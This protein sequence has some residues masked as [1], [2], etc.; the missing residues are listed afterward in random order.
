MNE[1]TV[2]W[3]VG[4]LLTLTLTLMAAGEL[5][6]IAAGTADSG[7]IFIW[8][9]ALVFSGV[10]ALIATRQPGNAIGWIFLSVGVS[11]GLAS[12]SSGYADYW[13]GGDGGSKALG[14]AAATY[15]STAWVPF[16]VVPVTFLL[17]LFPDGH[18]LSRR[19]R[20]IARLAGLAIASL[21]LAGILTP[22]PLEDYPQISS[23]YAIDSPL[24][25]PLAGLAFLALLVAVVG[26]GASLV[27][28]FR[29]ATG[30]QRQQM[31]WLALA[32]ASAAV[33]FPLI[34]VSSDFLG[35][36]L[37]NAAFML[38]VL[39]I[40]AA[41]AV[42]ILRY[43]LYDIDVVINRTLV[44][45]ALTATLAVVYLGSVL[46]LQLALGGITSDSN[47]A[48][49]ASTL[50]VAALFRPVRS[51]IQATVDRRFFRRRYDAARTLESFSAR[52]RDQVDLIALEAELRGVVA[53]TMQPAHVSLWVRDA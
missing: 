12:I 44:Y 10:G 3:L 9:I 51:R 20:P 50:A 23:P 47:L 45:G 37:S 29:R 7:E 2:R 19:W 42:A 28:R 13:V 6:G 16:I 49:A 17:L 31:K 26:S 1:R 18:L 15:G 40:P 36:G 11:A 35:D 14:E 22:G 52:L 33:A 39:T 48:I 27:V 4:A 21:L 38:C 41:A 46:L 8:T 32:G 43:R 34:L 25:D 5:L 53:E 30:E 24:I